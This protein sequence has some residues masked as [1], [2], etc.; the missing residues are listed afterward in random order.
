MANLSLC[1]P[2]G[3]LEL[4]AS[5]KLKICG[6]APPADCCLYPWPDPDGT[7]LYPATDLPDTVTNVG[8]GTFT[9]SGYDFIA[10]DE[11][12]LH[13]E[14]RATSPSVT[15]TSWVLWLVPDVGDETNEG[16]N[17]CLIGEWVFGQIE[18]EFP[19]TLFMDFENYEFSGT[20]E[21]SRVSLCRWEGSTTLSDPETTVTGFVEYRHPFIEPPFTYHWQARVES[22]EYGIINSPKTPPQNTPVGTYEEGI[23]LMNIYE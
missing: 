5:G 6:C 10:P 1:E 2:G 12:G 4:T 15:Q 13:Y 16:E 8:F 19:E 11:G 14:I 3:R 7:P 22:P 23:G 21:L 17:A 18:D 20:M 9:R